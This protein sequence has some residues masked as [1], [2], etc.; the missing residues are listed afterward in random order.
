MN[1]LEGKMPFPR[2]KNL[3]RYFPEGLKM[4]DRPFNLQDRD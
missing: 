1:E 3:D 4:R 2:W